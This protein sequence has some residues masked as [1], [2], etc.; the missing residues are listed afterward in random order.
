MNDWLKAPSDQGGVGDDEAVERL[1][2]T[3][4]NSSNPS[5]EEVKY[6]NC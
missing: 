2:I 3:G 1:M 6:L 5:G 4:S